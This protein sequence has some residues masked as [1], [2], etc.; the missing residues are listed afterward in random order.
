MVTIG[1]GMI[2]NDKG[3][4]IIRRVDETPIGNLGH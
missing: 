4:H 1:D 3:D 2:D